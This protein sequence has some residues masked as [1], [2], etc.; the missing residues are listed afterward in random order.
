ML[1]AQLCSAVGHARR[2]AGEQVDTH[3]WAV[4]G[5]GPPVTGPEYVLVYL[6]EVCLRCDEADPG[7]RRLE[8]SLPYL[9]RTKAGLGEGPVR[10]LDVS[11]PSYAQWVLRAARWTIGYVSQCFGCEALTQRLLT[12][13]PRNAPSDPWEFSLTLAAWRSGMLAIDPQ[14]AALVHTDRSGHVRSEFAKRLMARGDFG[15]VL[16]AVELDSLAAWL[17]DRFRPLDFNFIH[18]E[19]IAEF[20][21]TTESFPPPPWLSVDLDRNTITLEE[22]TYEVEPRGAALVKALLDAHMAGELPTATCRIRGRLQ[23]CNHDTTFRRWRE[24]LPDPIRA[25]I[26]G[27]EGAGIYLQR[28]SPT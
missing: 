9:Q 10:L 8:Q 16:D 7:A 18:H 25:C 3:P 11:A 2:L 5:S 20:E 12:A 19:L 28:P 1:T 6:A 13:F 24:R 26:R 23:N 21:A 14:T 27:S 4:A 22:K 15:A 17:R